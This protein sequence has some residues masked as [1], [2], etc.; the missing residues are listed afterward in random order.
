VAGS[1]SATRSSIPASGGCSTRIPT[2]LCCRHGSSTGLTLVRIQALVEPRSSARE[3]REGREAQIRN[4]AHPLGCRCRVPAEALPHGVSG[5]RC[6]REQQW[7]G[8]ASA[9]LLQE[10][11]RYEPPLALAT[12]IRAKRHCAMPPIES[13]KQLAADRRSHDLRCTL[14]VGLASA[15]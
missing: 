10:Q 6:G 1:R 11:I 13:S 2:W 9:L 8:P 3:V 5:R 14:M 12:A 15:E 4:E 7:L